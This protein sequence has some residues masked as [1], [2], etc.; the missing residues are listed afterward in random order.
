MMEEVYRLR[1]RQPINKRIDVEKNGYYF[2]N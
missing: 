2:T 1:R